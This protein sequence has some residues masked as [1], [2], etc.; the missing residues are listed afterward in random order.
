MQ[1]GEKNSII[2]LN[3]IKFAKKYSLYIFF[4]V[5]PIIKKIWADEKC[6]F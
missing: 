4:Y 3:C 5:G 6:H 1:V 2:K